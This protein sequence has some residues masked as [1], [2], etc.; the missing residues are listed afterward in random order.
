[1]N[2][3]V[4]P[5]GLFRYHDEARYRPAVPLQFSVRRLDGI[6][7]VKVT[8]DASLA[9]FIRVIA[10][11]GPLT[12][13]AGDKRVL[14]DLLGVQGDLKFT[15]HF[16]MGQEVG[17]HLK[18]LDRMASVVPQDKITRTSEKVA[19]TQGVHLR[20]FTSMNEAIDWL[21]SEPRPDRPA[22]S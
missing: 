19:M 13:T 3:R 18:H 2:S 11:L 7:S 21:K 17:Q 12:R 4:G 10:E 16:Q 8:G 22:A 5:T 15:D 1:M 9:E 14:V 6:T 20:V